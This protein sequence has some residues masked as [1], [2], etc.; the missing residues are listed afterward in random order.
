MSRGFFTPGW[1]SN[2][3][4]SDRM[5]YGARS[6]ARPEPLSVGKLTARE[7]Q[8]QAESSSVRSMSTDGN[9]RPSAKLTTDRSTVFGGHVRWLHQRVDALA[10]EFLFWR[11]A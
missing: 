5:G 7:V 10:H 6:C 4:T 8:A 9:N 2:R 11:Y 1:R 3:T